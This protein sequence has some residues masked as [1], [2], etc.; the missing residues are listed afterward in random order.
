MAES[1]FIALEESSGDNET[2]TS[3]C[4]VGKITGQKSLNKLA[5]SNIIRSSWKTR[6]EFAISPWE[7]NTFLFRFDN[8][9]DRSSVLRDGPWSVMGNLLVLRPIPE[10]ASLADI[11]F[12]I[13]PFW[14]Q[15]HGLPVEKMTKGNAEIIGRRFGRLVGIEA[16]SDGLLLNRS[17]LRVRVELNLNHPLPKGFWY[18]RN[19]PSGRDLWIS[20]KYEKLAD[21]CFACGRIGHDNRACK[22]VSREEGQASRF[23]PEMRAVAIRGPSLPVDDRESRAENPASW[24]CSSLSEDQAAREIVIHSVRVDHNLDKDDGTAKDNVRKPRSSP[25]DSPAGNQIVGNNISGLDPLTVSQ[26]SLFLNIPS[27]SSG[28]TPPAKVNLAHPF[29]LSFKP[30]RPA[31]PEPIYFVTEPNDSPKAQSPISGPKSFIAADIPPFL[32]P[33]PLPKPSPPPSLFTRLPSEDY[34]LSPLSRPKKPRSPNHNDVNLSSIFHNLLSLKRKTHSDPPSPPSN[35]KARKSEISIFS[36]PNSQ[37]DLQALSLS[38]AISHPKNS[39]RSRI[40]KRKPLSHKS[41]LKK[42]PTKKDGT[43]GGPL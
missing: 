7:T 16:L 38:P 37:P 2:K 35:S 25:L 33:L 19:S 41:P 3:L 43:F 36:S 14:V 10:G 20:Y 21:F 39:S 27:N 13:C 5:V 6:A 31:S 9:E 1:D 23:G 32:S 34:P 42:L 28:W 17:F 26:N 15:I 11:D 29:G 40:P 8:E 12:S 18:K 22:F 30:P 24:R 4:L